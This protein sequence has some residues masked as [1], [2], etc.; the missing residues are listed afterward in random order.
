VSG[1][2][3]CWSR[4]GQPSRSKAVD[5]KSMPSERESPGEE[6]DIAEES[7]VEG[8]CSQVEDSE[9]KIHKTIAKESRLLKAELRASRP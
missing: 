7:L 8:V 9:S 3:L 1:T 4:E 2:F 6:P 5:K